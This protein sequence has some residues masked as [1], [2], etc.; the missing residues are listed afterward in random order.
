VLFNIAILLLCSCTEHT[1]IGDIS[2][3]V[4]AKNIMLKTFDIWYYDKIIILRINV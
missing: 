4:Y 2:L 1:V 3:K